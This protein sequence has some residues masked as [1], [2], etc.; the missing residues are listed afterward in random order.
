MAF[1]HSRPHLQPAQSDV[2]DR[3]TFQQG[4]IELRTDQVT[5]TGLTPAL[6]IHRN[7]EHPLI[8]HEPHGRFRQGIGYLRLRLVSSDRHTF[9]TAEVRQAI[10]PPLHA[11]AASS[12][13]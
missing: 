8:V 13:P 10:G 6:D 9:E 1:G 12:D 7:D 11:P 2:M 4:R 3:E 5:D